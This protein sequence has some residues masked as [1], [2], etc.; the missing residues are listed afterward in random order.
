[1]GPHRRYSLFD[2]TTGRAETFFLIAA[3]ISCSTMSME[4]TR[5]AA[6]ACAQRFGP[7]RV[8]TPRF[9]CSSRSRSYAVRSSTFAPARSMMASRAAP[10]AVSYYL[11][12]Y[13][14]IEHDKTYG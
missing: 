10:R 6:Y 2:A 8:R 7:S 9:T 1:M 5:P 14:F 3:S 4:I 13:P 12:K 11:A